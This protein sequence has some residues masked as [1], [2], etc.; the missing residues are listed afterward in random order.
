MRYRI[1]VLSGKDFDNLPYPDTE[2]SL[3]IA[4][5]STNHAY[6]RYTG[7]QEVDKYLINH[8]VEHLI[9]R[10]GGEHSEHYRNGVYYKHMDHVMKALNSL[11]SR[12]GTSN[13][14]YKRIS[15]IISNPSSFLTGFGHRRSNSQTQPG[16]NAFPTQLGMNASPTNSGRAGTTS[17]ISNRLFER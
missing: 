12:I 2:M 16:M 6:I 8:E 7:L 10:S 4:D 13:P 14:A 17:S 9:D 11:S 15:G 5:P 3:G 1:Q